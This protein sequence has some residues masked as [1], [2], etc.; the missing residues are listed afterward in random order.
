MCEAS[1]QKHRCSQLRVPCLH[2]L[3]HPRTRLLHRWRISFLPIEALQQL[4]ERAVE[5]VPEY[6]CEDDRSLYYR[7]DRNKSWT[8]IPDPLGYLST[9]LLFHGS[10][11][12]L[13]KSMLHKAELILKR[14]SLL[15]NSDLACWD[16]GMV[17]TW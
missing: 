3:P 1:L 12:S 13:A 8:T 7:P 2:V 14:C 15:V 4:R 10:A 16:H 9:L 6:T 5:G 11:H 17:Q